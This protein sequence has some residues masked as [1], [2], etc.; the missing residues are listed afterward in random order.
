[1]NDLEKIAELANAIGYY[2]ADDLLDTTAAER[3]RLVTLLMEAKGGGARTF[4]RISA[5]R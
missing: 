3:D 2:S 1:M 5:A 4:R